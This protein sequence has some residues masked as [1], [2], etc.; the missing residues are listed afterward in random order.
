[1]R[2]LAHVGLVIG[3]ILALLLL[4]AGVE[5][6]LRIAGIGEGRRRHDPFAGFSRTVPLFEPAQSAEGRRILRLSEAR[7]RAATGHVANEPQREFLAEK[8]PGSF[9]VF[10]VGDSSAAG[11]PYGTKYAFSSWL[12]R[13]LEAELPAVPI[14]VVNAAISGYATRRIL[15]VVQELAA[16]SPDLVIVYAG[17]N[18]F[19]ERRFYAHLLELDPRVFRLWEGVVGTRLY[20]LLA[21]LRGSEPEPPRIDLD[22]RKTAIQMFAVLG[23]RAAGAGYPSA[24]EREYGEL[25]YRFNLEEIARVARSA[26]ARALFVTQSQNFADWA[27]GASQHREG[28]SAEDLARWDAAAAAGDAARSAGDCDAALSAWRSALAIDDAYADLVYRVAACERALG[29]F[30]AARRDYRR[31]SDLDRVPHGAPTRYNEIL[32]EVA[33]EEGALFTDADAAIERASEHGLVGDAW[34]ADFVH[35]RI[36]AHVTIADAV[37]GTL[38]AAG[39]PAPAASWRSDLYAPPDVDAIYR[40][41]PAPELQEH[42]VRALACMLALRSACSLSEARAVLAIDPSNDVARRMLDDSK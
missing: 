41:D 24:R 23:D 22:D 20:G 26:G 21:G 5:L 7:Q 2:A 9:R 17:H 31:A 42:L 25:L 29:R 4:L 8:P 13:R 40:S 35:P 33:R 14:E 32:R 27:P 39:L 19:A 12:E 10:V 18:E 3:S 34:F 30:E 11:V 38:Q 16:Y 37:A 15:T 1:M 28:L 6:A 36:R